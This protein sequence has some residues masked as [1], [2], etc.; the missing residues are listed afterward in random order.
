MSRT[1]TLS[2]PATP[3][4]TQAFISGLD[5][6]HLRQHSDMIQANFTLELFMIPDNGKGQKPMITYYKANS[7]PN[8]TSQTEPA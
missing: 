8:H 6:D 7:R 1:E 3:K 5:A 2:R 4:E